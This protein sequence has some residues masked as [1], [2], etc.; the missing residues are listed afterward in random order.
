[1]KLPIGNAQAVVAE[2]FESVILPAASAVGGMAPFAAGMASGLI[3]R[4]IPQLME[5]YSPTLKALGVLDADGKLDI[6]LLHE[7]AVKA[8]E[9][10]PVII[11]GYRADRGDLDKLKSIME[12]YGG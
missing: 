6:D 11:A 12:K 9:R 5:Q 2:Y 8:L 7:E 4:R 10:G 1:M 3:A